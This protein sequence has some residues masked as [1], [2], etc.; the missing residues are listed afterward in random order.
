MFVTEASSIVSVP[1][2]RPSH[3][4]FPHTQ[5][6]WPQL[7]AMK[8]NGFDLDLFLLESQ[9]QQWP[10]ALEWFIVVSGGKKRTSPRNM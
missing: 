8:P 2:L 3:V 5:T 6:V 7:Q 4:F 10:T 9:L 1:G